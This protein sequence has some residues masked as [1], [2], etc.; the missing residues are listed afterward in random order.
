MKNKLGFTFRATTGGNQP[1]LAEV[2]QACAEE[3]IL[4]KVGKG[5]SCIGG[6]HAED[7]CDRRWMLGIGRDGGR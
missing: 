2:V 6:G 1:R 5:D 7:W 4:D 3:D